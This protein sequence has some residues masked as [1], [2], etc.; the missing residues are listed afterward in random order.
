MVRL[1]TVTPSLK[2]CFAALFLSPTFALAFDFP[3]LSGRVVDQSGVMTA[4]AKSDV[5]AKSKALKDKSGIQLVVAT[6]KSW[7]AATS[8]LR[9]SAFRFWK[10][11]EAQKKTACCCWSRRSSTRCGSRSAMASCDA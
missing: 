4:E 6:V 1:R 10:L 3:A 9:Q 7:R 11:G 8:N 2:A 5:E